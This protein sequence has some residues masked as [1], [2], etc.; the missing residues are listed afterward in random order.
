MASERLHP[1]VRLTRVT[2]VRFVAT[3]AA[4]MA[5]ACGGRTQ[6]IPAYQ[7]GRLSADAVVARDAD[8]RVVVRT[9]AWPGEPLESRQLVPLELTVDN[10]STRTLHL[11]SQDVAF[12][13]SDGQRTGPFTAAE[14]RLEGQAADD[15]SAR[16]FKDGIVAPGGRVSGFLYFR[17][18]SEDDGLQLRIDLIDATDG[19]AFGVIEIPFYVD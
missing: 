12:V 8:V 13:T 14:L 19:T 18:P 5:I 3:A 4:L 1:L 16:A 9:E 17:E 11:R 6:L 7:I 10:D 15:L 2:A